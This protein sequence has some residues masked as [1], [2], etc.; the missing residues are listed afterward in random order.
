MHIQ[1]IKD[2]EQYLELRII[3][4]ETS[5][6]WFCGCDPVDL[7]S[8]KSLQQEIAEAKEELVCIRKRRIP[9]IVE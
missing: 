1:S 3:F 4:G 9:R 6:S 7:D 8:I 2:R 5:I